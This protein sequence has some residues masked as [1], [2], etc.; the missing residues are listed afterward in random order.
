[1]GGLFSSP[2]VLS[3]LATNPQVRLGCTQVLIQCYISSRI[4][5][6]DSAASSVHQMPLQC[7]A[8]LT[9]IATCTGPPPDDD[10]PLLCLLFLLCLLCLL[11]LQTRAFLGQPDFMQ[12]LQDLNRN[13][14][15]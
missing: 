1:M 11:F 6:P 10:A 14:G 3:R 8:C 7:T 15:G 12:M 13:P 2:E 4:L 5:H 9:H